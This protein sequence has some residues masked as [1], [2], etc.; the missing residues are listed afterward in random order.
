[1]DSLL[2]KIRSVHSTY[3]CHTADGL[4]WLNLYLSKLLIVDVVFDWTLSWS[5][6]TYWQSFIEISQLGVNDSWLLILGRLGP[7]KA[8]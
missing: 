6:K 8:V 3:V 7:I 1:M 4:F 5:P 2:S